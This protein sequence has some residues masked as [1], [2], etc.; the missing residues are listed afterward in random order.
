M[1]ERLRHAQKI[2]ALGRLDEGTAVDLLLTDMV[3]PG[4]M[5]GEKIAEAVLRRRPHARVVFSSGYTENHAVIAGELG[6][7]VAFLPKPYTQETLAHLVQKL[8]LG[9]APSVSVLCRLTEPE[10]RKAAGEERGIDP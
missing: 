3:L 9:S 7:G 4:G 8:L 2:E 5:N 6:E 10:R 1:E